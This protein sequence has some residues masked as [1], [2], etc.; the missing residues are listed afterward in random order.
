MAYVTAG[1][2]GATSATYTDSFPECFVGL[3]NADP[4]V[5]AETMRF[6]KESRI[7]LQTLE[8][9]ALSDKACERWVYNLGFPNLHFFQKMMAR[10][11]ENRY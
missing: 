7:A 2:I 11:E 4:T 6:T 5:V 10:L 8:K 9:K 3:R 1:E